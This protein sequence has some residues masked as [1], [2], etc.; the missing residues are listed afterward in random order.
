MKYNQKYINQSTD[1]KKIMSAIGVIKDYN[2]G[3]YL[4]VEWSHKLDK[5]SVWKEYLSHE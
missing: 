1:K 5:W 4:W 2:G 3:Q